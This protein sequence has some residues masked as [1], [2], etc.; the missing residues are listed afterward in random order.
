MAEEEVRLNDMLI[1]VV[2][3]REGNVK[4]VVELGAPEVNPL[5]RLIKEQAYRLARLLKH[6]FSL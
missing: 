5:R 2:R 6:L 4:Q 3:D 1:A